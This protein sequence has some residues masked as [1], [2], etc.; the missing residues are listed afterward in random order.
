MP[1]PTPP[2][3]PDLGR[4]SSQLKILREDRGLT[5]EQLAERAGL[6]RRGVISME[7]GERTGNIRSWFRVAQALG[8]SFSELM[9]ELD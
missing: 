4:L 5:Y 6:S 2:K 3:D 8:V 7:R 1:L 9:S